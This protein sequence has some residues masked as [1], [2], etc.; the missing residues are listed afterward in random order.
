M[1][2]NVK[3]SN[4]RM[5]LDENM[6]IFRWQSQ[7]SKEKQKLKQDYIYTLINQFSQ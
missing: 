6:F 7:D 5:F 1:K 2:L 4:S 3:Q